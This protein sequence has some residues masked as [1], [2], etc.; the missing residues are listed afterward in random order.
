MARLAVLSYPLDQAVGVTQQTIVAIEAGDYAPSVYPALAIC[1]SLPVLRPD[2][3]GQAS[4]KTLP[5][6]RVR[7]APGTA[8]QKGRKRPGY[9][10]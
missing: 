2:A 10:A 1:H 3:L 4:R 9:A 8:G 7:M 6:A 5:S